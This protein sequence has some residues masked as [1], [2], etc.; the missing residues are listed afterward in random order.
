MNK[1]PRAFTLAE[2]LVVLAI[3]LI[4]AGILFPVFGSAKSAAIKSTCISNFHQI[5]SSTLM[6]GSDYDDR[7]VLVNH[8]P[9][10][11]PNSRN[12][13]TW[14][15]MILPYL[16]NFSVFQCPADT[17]IRPKPEAS[18][19]QDLV[20]GDIYSQYY[21]A[22]LRTNAG[23]NFQ[24]LAPIVRVNN[25][26]TANPKSFT[27][28]TNPS[29]TLLFV[30]SVW[31]YETGKPVGGG[32]WLVVPPCRYEQIGATKFDTFTSTV[33]EDKGMDA[34][35]TTTEG[36]GTSQDQNSTQPNSVYGGAWPWHTDHMNVAKVDGSVRSTTINGLTQGCEVLS[37]WKGTIDD[38]ALYIWDTN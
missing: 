13:R 33:A 38:R 36:W 29:Q 8:Q 6:Y 12:D 20:P 3:I 16:K 19:D 22:S 24:Y 23:Y 25:R 37:N 17:S 1:T 10:E 2:L 18:F 15:Q 21:T 27:D 9:A 14:V 32:S 5:S 35:F 26:W 31:S 7:F 4:V 28:I 30:D 34:V 11:D